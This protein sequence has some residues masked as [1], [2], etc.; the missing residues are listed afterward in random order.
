MEKSGKTLDELMRQPATDWRGPTD[1]DLEI[2][3]NY[4][5]WNAA[6]ARKARRSEFDDE[7]DLEIISKGRVISKPPAYRR[8]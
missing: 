3:I 8:V 4:L 5:R 6:N 2:V 7:V 1:P